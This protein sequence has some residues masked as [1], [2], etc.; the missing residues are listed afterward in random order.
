MLISAIKYGVFYD[1]MNAKG[2]TLFSLMEKAKGVFVLVADSDSNYDMKFEWKDL[3][4][5]EITKM[6]GGTGVPHGLPD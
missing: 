4:R 3:H 6:N 5:W 2:A 1:S